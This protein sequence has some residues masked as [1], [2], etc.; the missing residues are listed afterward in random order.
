MSPHEA[1]RSGDSASCSHSGTSGDVIIILGKRKFANEET[2]CCRLAATEKKDRHM[3][4]V[5]FICTA[6]RFRSP[7]A[8]ACFRQELVTRQLDAGCQVSSAGT[9]TTDG[10]PATQS[11]ISGARY[12]G[13]NIAGH[14][15]RIVNA[16]LMG[17][18]DLIIVMEQGQKEALQAEFPRNAH[19][20][21]LLSEVCDRPVLRHSRSRVVASCW[22]C[23]C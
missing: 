10:M 15:S 1:I 11:A 13:L 16:E 14:R 6:N 20:V 7:I 21:H 4:V 19:K 23:P 5:L 8:E 12:L 2:P 17:E 18:A 9:W 22:R 3:P